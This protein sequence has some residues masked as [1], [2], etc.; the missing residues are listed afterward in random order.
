MKEIDSEY[1]SEQK[2]YDPNY[3]SQAML[4][5]E[6][7]GENFEKIRKLICI[8]DMDTLFKGRKGDILKY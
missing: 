4:Q 8:G 7:G 1:I 2:Y 3:K 5:I 6:F